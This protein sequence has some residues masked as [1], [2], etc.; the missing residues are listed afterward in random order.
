M[1][2]HGDQ[3]LLQHLLQMHV[4]AVTLCLGQLSQDQK[5]LDP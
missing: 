4:P 5:D 1:A 2:E 3:Q